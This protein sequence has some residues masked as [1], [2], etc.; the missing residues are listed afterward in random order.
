MQFIRPDHSI[1]EYDQ[2]QDF[3]TLMSPPEDVKTIL[4]NACYDCHSYH[5]QYPWYDQIAPVSYWLSGHVNHGRE[6]LNFS[7]WGTYSDKKSDHKLEE[8][9]EKVDNKSMPLKS[10]TWA[11]KKARLSSEQRASINSYFNSLRE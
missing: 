7:V 6:E 8:C 11:H 4:K 2:G 9:V 3:M 5:T 1:P 10:Y